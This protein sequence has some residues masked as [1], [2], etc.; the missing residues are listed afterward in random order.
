MLGQSGVY[1]R[2]PI[3]VALSPQCFS[4]SLK[5]EITFFFLSLGMY[6]KS[7][8][9]AMELL[10]VKNRARIQKEKDLSA[11]KGEED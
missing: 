11:G 1:E 5:G 2:Q 4:L 9:K 6:I 10:V 3:H 7:L 8:L